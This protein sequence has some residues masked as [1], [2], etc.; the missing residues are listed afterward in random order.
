M[1]NTSLVTRGDVSLISFI[2]TFLPESS[3]T[4]ERSMNSLERHTNLASIDKTK[5][6]VSAWTCPIKVLAVI[7]G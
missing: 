7:P 6:N 4:S 2:S 3:H 5:T 1:F